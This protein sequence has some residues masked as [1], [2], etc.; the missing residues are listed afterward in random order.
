MR[1]KKLSVPHSSTQIHDPHIRNTKRWHPQKLGVHLGGAQG[2]ANA[3]ALPKLQVSLQ[4]NL[5]VAVDFAS[6]PSTYK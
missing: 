2:Y 6:P 5:A 1:R 4:I 3:K